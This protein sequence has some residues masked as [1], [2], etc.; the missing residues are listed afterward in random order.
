MEN[1]ILLKEELKNRVT[2][3]INS[4]QLFQHCLEASAKYPC[5][6]LIR[7]GGKSTRLSDG[8]YESFMAKA[9]SVLP[10]QEFPHLYMKMDH[11]KTGAMLLPNGNFYHQILQKK[12]L[13]SISP[14]LGLLYYQW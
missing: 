3:K 14:I 7:N 12:M 5:G 2:N 6:I 10:K 9:E 8:Q 11:V 13:K 1:N 4:S